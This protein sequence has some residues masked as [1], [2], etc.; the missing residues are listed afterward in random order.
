VGEILGRFNRNLP[1]LCIILLLQSIANR[2][3]LFLAV[4][5]IYL[6][7]YF[8]PLA[9][10][11]LKASVEKG[12]GGRSCLDSPDVRDVEIIGKVEGSR[13]LKTYKRSPMSW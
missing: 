8:L 2:N 12:L 5:L 7:K 6:R 1:S 10:I 11:K 9:K 3:N 13:G 4:I